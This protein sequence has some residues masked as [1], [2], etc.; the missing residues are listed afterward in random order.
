MDLYLTQAEGHNH[1]LQSNL[2]ILNN[3]RS[4]EKISNDR[5]LPLLELTLQKNMIWK[6]L[7]NSSNPL[8]KS[9]VCLLFCLQFFV[10]FF[11]YNSLFTFFQWQTSNCCGWRWLPSNGRD[12]NSNPSTQY[13]ILFY[14]QQVSTYLGPNHLLLWWQISVKT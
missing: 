4:P 5:D 8:S 1:H 9:A 12:K 11:V 6:N 10:C 7:L 3:L 14:L 2:L 13:S